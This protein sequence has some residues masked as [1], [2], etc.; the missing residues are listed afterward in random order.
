MKAQTVNVKASTGRILCSTIFR[1][2]GRKLLAKG[3]MLSEEDIRLLETEGLNE[4]WVTEL[5]DGEV[6]EDD[7]VCQAAR[8]IGCGCLEIR[9]AAGGRANLFATEDCC[10]LVDD[11]LLRQINCTASI[12]IATG[13]NFSMAKAGQRIATVKSAPFAVPRP[14]LETV[15]SMLRERRFFRRGR[16]GIL[17][18]RSFIPIRFTAIAPASFLKASCVNGWS[19]FRPRRL[20]RWPALKKRPPWRIAWNTWFAPSRP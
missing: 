13:V 5:E 6:G 19:I 9:L 20:S 17:R 15:V 1:A 8:E 7:A 14:Q 4:V 3:H 16:C 2:G 10:L 11:E 12:V 18:S